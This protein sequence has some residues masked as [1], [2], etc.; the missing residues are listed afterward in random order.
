MKARKALA[1]IQ[2]IAALQFDG[3]GEDIHPAEQMSMIESVLKR[4]KESQ[5]ADPRG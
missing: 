5:D 2:E 1:K 4:Y 3:Y